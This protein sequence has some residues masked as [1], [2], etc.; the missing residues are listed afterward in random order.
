MATK[1]DEFGIDKKK[2]FLLKY[3][4][5]KKILPYNKN[6]FSWTTPGELIKYKGVDESKY[7]S[8]FGNSWQRTYIIIYF[9]LKEHRHKQ[10]LQFW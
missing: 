9:F 7:N 3:V 6:K 4:K 1:T 10:L 8:V 2:A 5:L